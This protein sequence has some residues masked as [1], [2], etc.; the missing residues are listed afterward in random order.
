VADRVDENDEV[1]ARI[2]PLA[3]L[4]LRQQV[5]RLSAQPRRAKYRVRASGVEHPDGAIAQ[6]KV[7]NDGAPL[8]FEFTKRCELLRAC[9]RLRLRACR[10]RQKKE[11]CPAK[12]RSAFLMVRD[13]TSTAEGLGSFRG[14][15]EWCRRW[16][17]NPRPRDYETLALPLSYTGKQ[18]ILDATVSLRKVSSRYQSVTVT[19]RN[20]LIFQGRNVVVSNWHGPPK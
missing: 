6:A 8:Q 17:S 3:R 20:R 11:D 18:S 10:A 5:L 12:S 9:H 2:Q 4:C 19:G 7:T 14:T 16:D 1:L 13:C 15:R